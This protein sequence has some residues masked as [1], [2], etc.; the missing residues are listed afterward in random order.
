MAKRVRLDVMRNRLPRDSWRLTR[1][2]EQ[3]FGLPDYPLPFWEQSVSE[4]PWRVRPRDR[5]A[6]A[7]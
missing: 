2:A 4:H 1:L 6:G 5:A 7:S 3:R